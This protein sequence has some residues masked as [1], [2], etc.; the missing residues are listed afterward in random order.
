MKSL[1]RIRTDSAPYDT[2]LIN[3]PV[4][5]RRGHTVG[6]TFS[7]RCVIITHSEHQARQSKNFSTHIQT[8]KPR[9]RFLMDTLS[10][11]VL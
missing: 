3:Q 4:N 9:E 6:D 11:P 2:R 5:P 7:P 1:H 10:P 8:G